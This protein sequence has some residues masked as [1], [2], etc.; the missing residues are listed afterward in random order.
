SELVVGVKTTDIGKIGEIL[1]TATQAGATN[2]S[3]V[4]FDLT[5]STRKKAVNDALAIATKDATDKANA[6][7]QSMGLKIDKI[8]YVTESGVSV[9]G[10]II[11]LQAEAASK[12]GAVTPP[13]VLPTEIEVM[14]NI[15]AVFIF[16][17]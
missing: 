8:S 7:A 10:P 13:P 9:P 3:S 16:S 2:I 14:A 12:A 6:I 11:S 5:D 4:G 15:T 1:A 17:K